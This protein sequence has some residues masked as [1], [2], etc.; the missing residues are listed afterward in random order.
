M[1]RLVTI[2]CLAAF[3]LS[4]CAIGS[5]AGAGAGA[6]VAPADNQVVTVQAE[7]PKPAFKAGRFALQ[8][9]SQPPQSFI[10]SFDLTGGLPDGTLNIYNPLGLQMARLEWTATSAKLVQGSQVGYAANLESLVYQLTGTPLPTAALIDWLGGKPTP[11]E[12]WNVDVSEW[13]LRRLV[14]ER[15]QPAPRTVLRIA[16]ES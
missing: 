1:K 9:D 10:L 5:G 16:F 6:V 4:A 8:V 13:H 3:M 14:L 11:A 15:V 7:V 2:S 12:G